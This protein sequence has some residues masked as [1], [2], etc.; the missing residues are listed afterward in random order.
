MNLASYSNSSDTTDYRT[1]VQK[2]ITT[3]WVYSHSGSTVDGLKPRL[4]LS[5]DL[6]KTL[7]FDEGSLSGLCGSTSVQSSIFQHLNIYLP[8]LSVQLPWYTAT[9]SFGKGLEEEF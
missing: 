6:H 2:K 5:P 9:C 7:L 4:H 8:F 1:N 3:E